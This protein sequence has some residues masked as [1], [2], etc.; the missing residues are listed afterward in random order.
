MVP[1]ATGRISR[2]RREV[3]TYDDMRLDV[4]LYLHT[5]DE[6]LLTRRGLLN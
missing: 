5:S 2:A 6:K 4:G 3:I 1:N